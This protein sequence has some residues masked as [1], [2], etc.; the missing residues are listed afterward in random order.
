MSLVP[1]SEEST[2]FHSLFS[3]CTETDVSGLRSAMSVLAEYE[4]MMLIVNNYYDI[5]D[6]C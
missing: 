3:P 2:W 4:S 1:D 6:T 5:N